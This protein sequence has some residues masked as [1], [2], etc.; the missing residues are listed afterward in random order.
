MYQ[1]RRLL[2]YGELEVWAKPIIDT[3]SGEMAVGLL[4]RSDTPSNITFK[5]SDI[6]IKALEGYTIRDIWA[7]KT[8]KLPRKNQLG[9]KFLATGL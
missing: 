4:N 1:A 9:W 8:I 3:M 6:G 7:V 5:L 2:D